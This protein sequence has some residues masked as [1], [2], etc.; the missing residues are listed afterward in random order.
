MMRSDALNLHIYPVRTEITVMK[1]IPTSRVC[2]TDKSELKKFLGNKTLSQS[3]SADKYKSKG[4][5][6]DKF[7][8]EDD[9]SESKGIIVKKSVTEEDES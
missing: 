3:C 7:S 2:S 1:Q 4:I 9:K 6:V 8:T 5:I